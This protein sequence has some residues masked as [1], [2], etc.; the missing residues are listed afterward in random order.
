MIANQ[1][2][3]VNGQQFIWPDG[4]TNVPSDSYPRPLI[5]ISESS[6]WS[7]VGLLSFLIVCSMILHGL[8]QLYRNHEILRANS[9][10]FCHIIVLGTTLAYIGCIMHVVSHKALLN[11]NLPM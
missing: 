2:S 10:R 3:F 1:V 11:C 4:S 6:K 9:P 8:I 7:S 5:F